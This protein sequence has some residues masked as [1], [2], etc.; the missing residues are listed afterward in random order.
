[1]L[2]VHSRKKI[3]LPSRVARIKDKSHKACTNKEAVHNY[4]TTPPKNPKTQTSLFKKSI[5]LKYD[6]TIF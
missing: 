3:K 2:I 5:N 6:D 1:M 4:D